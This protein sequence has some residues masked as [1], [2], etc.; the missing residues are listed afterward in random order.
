[1]FAVGWRQPPAQR[2]RWQRRQHR[3]RSTGATYPNPELKV[4]LDCMVERGWTVLKEQAPTRPVARHHGQPDARLGRGWIRSEGAWHDSGVVAFEG[5]LDRRRYVRGATQH[6]CE[7][8]SG[9]AGLNGR[10]RSEEYEGQ[11]QHGYR[12]GSVMGESSA[13]LLST[14][15]RRTVVC[16]GV[17]SFSL[18][19]T[20]CRSRA[21]T[22][23][24][25]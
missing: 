14:R 9:V 13:A 10:D 25:E 6:H 20:R 8:Y 18:P 11:Q 4:W 23:P 24:R 5:Q 22:V 12:W 7:T 15:C 21:T 1:M 16:S 3:R 19:P 2:G 17:V